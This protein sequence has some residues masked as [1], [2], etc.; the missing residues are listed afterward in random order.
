MA[1]VSIKKVDA[2]MKISGIKFDSLSI[3][4]DIFIEGI[5]KFICYHTN[6]YYRHFLF[7][8][9]S[10]II[11]VIKEYC[12]NKDK[13]LFINVIDKVILKISTS[14]EK[15]FIVIGNKIVENFIKS[16][17]QSDFKDINKSS[18]NC[19]FK[20]SDKFLEY[21]QLYMKL[22]K[23]YITIIKVGVK[24]IILSYFNNVCKDELSKRN[25]IFIMISAVADFIWIRKSATESSEVVDDSEN[26]KGKKKSIRDN[27]KLFLMKTENPITFDNPNVKDNYLFILKNHTDRCINNLLSDS[28]IDDDRITKPL[29]YFFE[30]YFKMIFVFFDRDTDHDRIVVLKSMFCKPIGVKKFLILVNNFT[31]TFLELVQLKESLTDRNVTIV[32]KN[33]TLKEIGEIGEID[34]EEIEEIEERK[35]YLFKFE[36]IVTPSGKTI[37]LNIPY[38]KFQ[39]IPSINSNEN[40]SLLL[41]YI[42][43]LEVNTGTIKLFG[44]NIDYLKVNDIIDLINGNFIELDENCYT[45]LLRDTQH[46]ERKNSDFIECIE[47]IENIEKDTRIKNNLKIELIKKYAKLFKLYAL[48]TETPISRLEIGE[49]QRLKI[50]KLIIDD[51][52]NWIL[53]NAMSSINEDTK[54]VI[55]RELIRLQIKHN[56][57]LILYI[58]GMNKINV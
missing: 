13:D 5:K 39:Y 21:K 25:F 7:I 38:G 18:S 27:I 1:S 20:E 58:P 53:D 24:L 50:I 30:F 3:V 28:D 40:E 48:E 44:E 19:N 2:F 8:V 43:N 9:S 45:Y 34:E 31:T 49:V 57:T 16:D 47:C 35:K 26:V 23:I 4:D 14:I 10:S 11:E 51:K 42:L 33:N 54:K 37:N 12:D 36:N 55:L 56:K 22:W 46:L 41:K 52:P 29:D 15:H 32:T 17:V 6:Q